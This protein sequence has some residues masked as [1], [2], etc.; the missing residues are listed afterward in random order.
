MKF[1][2]KFLI[3]VIMSMTVLLV[4]IFVTSTGRNHFR[5]DAAR[6]TEPSVRGDNLI[7]SSDLKNLKG[8][9]LFVNLMSAVQILMKRWCDYH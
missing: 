5:K 2:R 8:E 1:S 3:A 9:I 7:D 6:W 4:L